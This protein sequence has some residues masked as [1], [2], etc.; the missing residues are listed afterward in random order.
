MNEQLRRD[1]GGW[2]SGPSADVE[3]VEARDIQAGDMVMLDGLPV[4]VTAVEYGKYWIG[5]EFT[6]GVKIDWEAGN[7]LGRMS[8]READTLDRIKAPSR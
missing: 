6:D 2:I 8:R 1:I 5:R 3:P 7:R 4:K